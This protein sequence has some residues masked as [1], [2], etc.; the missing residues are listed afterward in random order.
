MF[1]WMIILIICLVCLLTS[2]GHI[3]SAAQERAST[4]LG[5][6]RNTDLLD[7]KDPDGKP[8]PLTLVIQQKVISKKCRSPNL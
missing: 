2:F 7:V 8:L 3:D 1:S 5:R 6:L 4:D